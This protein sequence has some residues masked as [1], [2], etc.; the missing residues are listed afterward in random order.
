M[1]SEDI[2]STGSKIA[3]R[4]Q[5]AKALAEEYHKDQ[6]YGL[7]DYTYHLEQV[8]AKTVFLFGMDFKLMTLAYSHDLLEDTQIEPYKLRAA[9]GDEI[10]LAVTAI[11]KQKGELRKDYIERCKENDLAKK[12]KIADTLSNLEHCVKDNNLKRVVYYSEQLKI[13]LS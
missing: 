4:F 1:N 3:Q 6:K 9:V 2:K 5:K 7:H 11:T 8:L 12:C 10:F 13:L